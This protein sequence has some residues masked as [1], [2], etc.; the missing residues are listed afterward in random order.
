MLCFSSSTTTAV[1]VGSAF[2]EENAKKEEE[3]NELS[4]GSVDELGECSSADGRTAQGGVVLI[5]GEGSEAG[6]GL[7]D[8]E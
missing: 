6:G 2:E 3:G 8:G 1:V 7:S 5:E 4:E